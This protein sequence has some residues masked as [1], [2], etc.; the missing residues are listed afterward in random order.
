MGKSAYKQHSSF[1]IGILGGTFDPIHCGHLAIAKQAQKQC[2]LTKVIFVP[3]AQSPLKQ[4]QMTF[5]PAESRLEMARLAVKEMPG[6]EVS[7]LEI[8]RG[9][10][11][12]TVE[13]LKKFR[14]NY[15][16]AEFFLILGE[17]NLRDFHKWRD[18]DKI[19][20]L[21]HILVAPREQDSLTEP[22]TI[23]VNFTKLEA[24]LFPVSATA[25]REALR[26]SSNFVHGKIPDEV[27]NY[28]Q[29]HRL[30][31]T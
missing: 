29:Q 10:I 1:R 26:S 30:Y 11:S 21:A 3:A 9:G 25:I 5:A 20:E 13:T 16:G 17:D 23:P 8:K 28:I 19:T 31:Q 27:L 18:S 2:G 6:C 22:D 15:P 12:Y 7:D 4:A 24:P 14:E